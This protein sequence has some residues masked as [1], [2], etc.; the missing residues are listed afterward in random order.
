MT[1]IQAFSEG[2][3]KVNRSK[4]LVFYVWF[5]NFAIA[6]LLAIPLLNQLDAYIAPTIN[7]ERLLQRWD[8]NWYQTFRADFEKNDI[9]SLLNYSILGYAPFATNLN[10]ILNGAG[11]RSIA[12]FFIDLFTKFEFRTGGLGILS[13]LLLFYTLL[14]TYFA[15]GFISAYS[16][17][18]TF[19]LK[20]F[21]SKGAT[22]FG[23]FFRL[24][25]LSLLLFYLF[26][27]LIDSLNHGIAS[28][29][30]NSPTEMTPFLWYFIRN[31]FFFFL[32]AVFMM[33]FDYAKIRFIVDDRWSALGAFGAG[34]KFSI[35]NFGST[36]PLV[37]L[38][39]ILGIA[40]MALYG[41]LEH[42]I[43]QTGY[44]TILIVFFLEQL[45]MLFRICV[46]ALFYG[47]QTALFQGLSAE[48]HASQ[49]DTTTV[50][51]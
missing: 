48:Q 26:A 33:W 9:A 38:L 40:L 15:G 39:T 24:F 47:T 45:Y 19:T 34:V 46:K 44:W 12:G 21:L 14:S 20:E 2:L 8:D 17:D 29:T 3:K 7:E 41:F 49:I 1:T 28:I 31:L 10:G 13:L 22:Y 35:K 11:I 30:A 25:L 5:V 16:Q 42:L 36:F 23:R 37:L 51:A 50:S 18:S 27:L 6:M 4:R 43:P 32:L